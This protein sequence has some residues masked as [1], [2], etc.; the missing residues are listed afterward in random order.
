MDLIAS[1]AAWW[2]WGLVDLLLL[3]G[4]RNRL[5]VI[6][7][8]RWSYFSFRASTRLITEPSTRDGTSS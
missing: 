7:N 6:L 2:L 8:W 4:A 5:A 1:A 3:V